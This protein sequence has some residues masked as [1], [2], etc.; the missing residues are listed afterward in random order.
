MDTL[1]F[2]RTSFKVGKLLSETHLNDLARTTS[3]MKRERKL[4]GALFLHSLLHLVRCTPAESLSD[5]CLSYYNR[6]GQL[7]SRQAFDQRFSEQSVTYVRRVLEELLCISREQ[8]IS[9][10][11]CTFFKDIQILDSTKLSQ[12][13][14][15]K[16]Q[17]EYRLLSGQLTY[18]LTEPGN[19]QDHCHCES[20]LATVE[21]QVLYLR[22]K[23]YYKIA[24]MRKIAEGKAFFLSRMH[25]ESVFYLNGKK[26]SLSSVIQS[27]II[28][29]KA[30]RDLEVEL[31]TD[32]HYPVRLMI[33]LIDVE[34]A[35][36]RIHHARRQAR[37]HNYKLLS[38][39][40][41][42]SCADILVTNIPKTKLPL[43]KA[44]ELY[45]FRGQIE[46]LFRALKSFL[47]AFTY[48]QVNEY[49]VQT[50]V[51]I[52]MIAVWLS[53]D[54]V[55]ATKIHCWKKHAVEISEL[56]AFR[57]LCLHC[58]HEFLDHLKGHKTQFKR[59][60]TGLLLAFA[61]KHE[62]KGKHTPYELLFAPP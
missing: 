16:M 6:C 53:M 44:L 56:K 30:T 60:F 31:T 46:V 15:L 28:S 39:T 23:G 34:Q 11:N 20:T 40:I 5:M 17:L 49:R 7:V 3:F 19:V 8:F 1:S 54:Q 35:R 9:P 47:Q 21:S 24:A 48:K 29:G 2:D 37:S 25:A 4:S 33:K 55:W 51:Y 12:K 58:W 10:M 13:P 61:I 18:L 36:R 27:M 22:D 41:W 62:P 52:K 26:Q 45:H 14:F 43:T 57:V 50:M 38:K 59:S 42:A 32:Y